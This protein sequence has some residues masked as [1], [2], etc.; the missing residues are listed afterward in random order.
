MSS[1]EGKLK[2]SSSGGGTGVWYCLLWAYMQNPNTQMNICTASLLFI[3]IGT[4]SVVGFH[5]GLMFLGKEMAEV[6]VGWF[7]HA[8]MNHTRNTKDTAFAVMKKASRIL[9]AWSCLKF[10]SNN[11]NIVLCFEPYWV[12]PSNWIPK[13]CLCMPP[14]AFITVELVFL[15]GSFDCGIVIVWVVCVITS[16]WTVAS[17]F[18]ISNIIFTCPNNQL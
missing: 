11:I 12:I 3:I 17:H 8:G 2:W 14:V 13:W 4:C 16:T 9:F 18:R 10:L 7:S 1:C 6:H 5:Q 15:G